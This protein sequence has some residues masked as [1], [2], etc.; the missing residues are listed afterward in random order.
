MSFWK[1]NGRKLKDFSQKITKKS[2]FI[3]ATSFI[4]VSLFGYILNNTKRIN[5]NLVQCKTQNEDDI[6]NNKN[7]LE[8]KNLIKKF[9]VKF[10][11]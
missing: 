2:K 6:I 7:Y 11:F 4:S 5:S 3:L 9:K 8:C 1:N 10:N